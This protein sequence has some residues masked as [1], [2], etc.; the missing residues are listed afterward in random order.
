MIGKGS[1]VRVSGPPGEVLA[2]IEE[3]HAPENLPDIPELGLGLCSD[4]RAM[5]HEDGFTHAALISYLMG[6]R[7]VVFAALQDRD[8]CWWDLKRQPLTITE[9]IQETKQ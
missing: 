2:E 9:L 8:G 5:L 1:L 6:S 7:R 3:M 4:A